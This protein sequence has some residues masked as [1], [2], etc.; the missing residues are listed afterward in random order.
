MTGKQKEGKVFFKLENPDVRWFGIRSNPIRVSGWVFDENGVPPERVLVQTG[1]RIIHLQNKLERHDVIDVFS[2]V[3]NPSMLT[4]FEGAFKVRPGFKLLQIFAEWPD[5]SRYQLGKHLFWI[6][7]H[8]KASGGIFSRRTRHI[9]QKRNEAIRKSYINRCKDVVAEHSNHS[10]KESLSVL[11]PVYRGLNETRNCLLSLYASQKQNNSSFEII[12]INDK[13]PELEL[14][15]FLENEAETGRFTLLQNPENLGFVATVNRGICQRQKMDVIILNSDTEVYGD[16]VD[17]IV[18]AANKNPKI[19]TITPFS[20]NATICSYPECAKE[21]ELPA[22]ISGAGLDQLFRERNKGIIRDIPTGVGFCMFIRRD[23][24][25]QIGYLDQQIFGKGYGE[26]NDFCLRAALEGWR[27]VLLCDTFVFHK[28]A[29]SFQSLKNIHVN[30]AVLTLNKLY[31]GYD[32]YIQD[33]LNKDPAAKERLAIDEKRISQLASTRILVITNA[34]A[35]GTLQHIREISEIE[36][37]KESRLLIRPKYERPEEYEVCFLPELTRVNFSQDGIS[38]E[39][40]KELCKKWKVTSLEFHHTADQSLKIYSLPHETGLPYRVITHD[41][42]F[43]CPQITLS[44]QDG[45]YCG[46]PG[47]S[48][49]E[50]CLTKRPVKGIKSIDGWRVLNQNFLKNATEV[51]SPSTTAANHIRTKYPQAKYKVDP[52]PEKNL[53]FMGLKPDWTHKTGDILTIGILGALNREKGADILEK[54]TINAAKRDLPLKFILIGYAYRKFRSESESNLIVTGPYENESVD[55][56][57][58]THAPNLFWFPALWPETYSYTLSIAMERRFPVVVPSLGA[59]PDRVDGRAYSWV[60]PWDLKAEAF[61]DFFIEVS[62]SPD[63]I[64]SPVQYPKTFT[65]ES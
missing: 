63:F 20:N 29:V 15:E 59:F 61:N 49:C 8:P 13:S 47:L 18:A 21:N 51:I 12:V 32:A 27:N 58:K 35:G 39:A 10:G 53:K 30:K 34:R 41:Y 23:T 56:I 64:Y 33:H 7:H 16:W 14:T 65:T 55:S 25:D 26:E 6:R 11:I 3:V 48:E 60:I 45:K 43:F 62:R 46:E 38:F 44:R 52:H 22:P 5:E 28:G 57:I 19:A 36:R 9:H 31:P 4:G 50:A 37:D 24:L 54:T 2:G 17:R 1:D 42:Y 40:I